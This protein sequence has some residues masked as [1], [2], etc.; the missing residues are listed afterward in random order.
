MFECGRRKIRSH[1]DRQPAAAPGRRAG[2]RK[3]H[4]SPLGCGLV[5][6]LERSVRTVRAAASRA[7]RPAAPQRRVR[8]SQAATR[9][10]KWA[11]G[12]EDLLNFE[13]AIPAWN[14]SG[15]LPRPAKARHSLIA[16]VRPPQA[17]AR[18][19]IL[20]FEY[21]ILNFIYILVPVKTASRRMRRS[22][23]SAP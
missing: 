23:R 3:S 18:S 5:T 13:F 17:A 7:R 4:A 6:S 11:A 2:R 22:S 9:I 14:R 16:R 12:P 19:V 1:G 8:P 15:P 20:N 10:G 21:R